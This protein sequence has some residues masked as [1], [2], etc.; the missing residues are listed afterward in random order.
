[1]VPVA[2]AA[3]ATLATHGGSLLTNF[4]GRGEYRHI[5]PGR[6]MAEP[7]K[8]VVVLHLTI[9]G[10]AFFVASAGTPVAALVVMVV[11]KTAVTS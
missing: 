9:L 2:L 7:Y 5:S 3:G 8:R 6:Q 1:L 4:V 10:G 11:V